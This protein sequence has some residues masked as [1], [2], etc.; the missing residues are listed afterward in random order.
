CP[1]SSRSSPQ[2]ASP[3]SA[4]RRGPPS[5]CTTTCTP[6]SPSPTTWCSSALSTSRTPASRTPRTCWRST[7]QPSR[8]VWR[9]SWTPCGPAIRSRPWPRRSARSLPLDGG[10]RLRGEVER[11]AV[12]G[13]DLV[14]DPARDRLQQVVGQARPVGR[15]RVLGGDR[16]DHDR[17]AVGAL[18][19]LDTD[20]A[21]RRQDG[22]A[23]PELA[24][25]AGTAPLL[26]RD[27][28]GAGEDLEPFPR[29]LADDPDRQAGAGE[30]VAPDHRLRQ[31]ELFPHSPHLVLEQR[32]ERLD[33]LHRHVLGEPADVVMRL[34]LRGDA[35]GAAG[36][37]HVRVERPLAEGPGLPQLLGF[38]LEHTDELLADDSSLL[39]RLGD[40]VEAYEEAVD[41][42]DVDERHVEVALEGLDHLGGLVLAQ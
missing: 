37:D 31:P 39:L 28:A 4:R 27:A 30:R 40:A 8:S 6:R 9:G 5:R 42:V 33:E 29:A 36:L 7:T 13:R 24:V 2:D 12:H 3:G 41:G 35:L 21:D 11:D 17:V 14:D 15:H 16:A 32:P 1:C 19:T 20:R 18:V 25:E 34:D 10:G 23:L 26:E 22:E 38:L